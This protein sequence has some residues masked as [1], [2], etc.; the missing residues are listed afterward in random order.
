MVAGQAELAG[1]P[2]WARPLLSVVLV[3]PVMQYAVMPVLT[4]A[5]RGLLY[6]PRP[7]ELMEG[8]P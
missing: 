1:F 8:A 5:A 7:L 4:R 6:P 2:V 3:I